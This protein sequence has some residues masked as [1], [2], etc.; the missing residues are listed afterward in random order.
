M[1]RFCVV[2]LVKFVY[3][4]KKNFFDRKFSNIQNPFLESN[5]MGYWIALTILS[6][7]TMIV[8]RK[9]RPLDEELEPPSN[10][11]MFF[12]PIQGEGD[13]FIGGILVIYF[14]SRMFL[15]IAQTVRSIVF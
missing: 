12:H 5:K 1:Y 13:L 15:E 10:L 3:D 14:S 2:T 6:L 9:K 11:I 4:I 7:V 8:F